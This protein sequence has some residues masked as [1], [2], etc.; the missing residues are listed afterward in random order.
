METEAAAN[1]LKQQGA[2]EAARDPQSKVTA[3][4]AEQK[5]VEDSREAG[6]TAFTFDP[7]ASPEQKKAQAREVGAILEHGPNDLARVLTCGQAIPDGLRRKPKGVAIVTD[8]DG[9]A[10]AD[11]ELPS[12]SKDG[13]VQVAK[14]EGGKT[15]ANGKAAEE[16]EEE[17][18]GKTGWAPRFGWP[19]ESAHEGESML[20]HTTW[21]ESQLPEKFFGGMVPNPLHWLSRA[22]RLIQRKIGTTMRPSSHSPVSRRGWWPC[23]AVVSPGCSS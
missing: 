18:W 14:S 2:I 23:L 17:D 20:D 6:V 12:P 21:A 5:I 8:M 22:G 9:G 10:K 13:A 19:N 11:V 16:E 7:D 3:E 1:E 4:D 15:L